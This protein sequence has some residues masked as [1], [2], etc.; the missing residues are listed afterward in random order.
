VK[1]LLAQAAAAQKANVKGCTC[2]AGYR[3][4]GIEYET[5][6]CMPYD[7]ALKTSRALDAMGGPDE[8]RRR[9]LQRRRAERWA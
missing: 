3:V 2:G 8:W 7:Q 6:G 5:G 4:K 1:S 9:Y